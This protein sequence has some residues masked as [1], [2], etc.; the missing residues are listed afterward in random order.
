MSI[1]RF[2]GHE[3]F[4]CKQLW[5]KKGF[6]FLNNGN[7]FNDSD[8]IVKLGVGK[9]MVLSIRY[10][11]KS[12]GLI[13]ENDSLTE[14]AKKILADDGFDPYLEDVG[15]IWLFHYFLVSKN[16]ASIY[17]LVFNEFLKINNEFTK[18][19]LHNH[20]KRISTNTIGSSYN[21]HTVNT[22]INVF[23]R[24][25]MQ[26]DHESKIT[27]FE[28]EYSGLFLDLN[29][30]KHLKRQDAEEQNKEYY[31][32]ERTER[33]SLPK[34][35]FL[36]VVLDNMQSGNSISFNELVSGSNSVGNVFQL[37]RDG[38]Y[39]KIEELISEVGF[40]KFTHT[41]GIPLLT[42]TFKPNAQDILA[43]YY[44]NVHIHS[45]D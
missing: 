15:T 3:S 40:L 24:N 23:I 37:N 19:G 44:E 16:Y 21:E 13:D 39:Q 29:L 43:S 5:P 11:M 25:Y 32:I 33:K 18:L 28:D 34:E 35:I 42:F 2:S 36:Y 12:L 7:N 30:I 26:P 22:D 10:W 17:N 31:I 8:A 4:I 20:I 6:D 38:V 1:V 27:S 9:N 14:V 41:A 45:V